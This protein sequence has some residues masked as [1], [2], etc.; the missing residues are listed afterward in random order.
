[1]LQYLINRKIR[2]NVEEIDFEVPANGN[3]R[4]DRRQSQFHPL[5]KSKL[6]AVQKEISPGKKI[7]S[8]LVYDEAVKQV[9]Q[10]DYDY[11]DVPRSKKQ[12]ID[13]SARFGKEM[14]NE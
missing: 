7:N 12:I 10:N 3:A 9:S 11:G 14:Q 13:L 8:G 6:L 2:G 1:M 5:K 4:L